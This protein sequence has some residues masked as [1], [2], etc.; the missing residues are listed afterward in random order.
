MHL[1]ISLSLVCLVYEYAKPHEIASENH[2][3]R[4]SDL[5]TTAKISEAVALLNR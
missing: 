3:G 1:E 5:W 2:D 4:A